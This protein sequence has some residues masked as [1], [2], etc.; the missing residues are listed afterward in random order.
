MIQALNYIGFSSPRYEE[1]LTFGPEVLG[2]QLADRGEDG[3]VRL[4]A[5]DAAHRLSIHPGDE[6]ALEYIGWGVHTEE[7][8]AALTQRLT[9]HGTKVHEGTPEEIADRAVAGMV[10]FDDPFGIRHEL[11]WGQVRLPGTFH[12]GRAMSGF[13]TGEQGLGHGVLVVPDIEQ[14]DDFF[15]GVLGF[16]LSDRIIDPPLNARFYH[17]NGRHHSLAVAEMPG[18]AGFQHLM[19]ETRSLD[20]VGIAYDLCE[21]RGVPIVLTMGRHTNDLT[22]SF[23]LY[24]PAGFHIEYGTGGVTVDDD[25][26][27]P[28]TYPKTKIW[29]HRGT[30]H[31]DELPFA[32]LHPVN[33]GL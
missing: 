23:Y 4:R 29:G 22:T 21:E 33:E 5:D 17:C 19:L 28:A 16:R 1:W 9:D 24:S 11:S 25:N 27:E 30:R 15:S 26:W 14:A 32:I 7:D 12:P 10:W 31:R 2:L 18:M 6:H 13:I 8:L 20:D 3:T